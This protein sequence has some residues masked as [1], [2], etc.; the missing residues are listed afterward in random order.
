MGGPMN[1]SPG[2]EG[3]FYIALVID[4]LLLFSAW[5]GIKLLGLRRQVI[6][7]WSLL[8]GLVILALGVSNHIHAPPLDGVNPTNMMPVP[9]F[10]HYTVYSFVGIFLFGGAWLI[11]RPKQM[12][13]E[14]KVMRMK[15]ITRYGRPRKPASVNRELAILSGIFTMA[16]DYEEIAQ[17]PCRKV[18]TI[19]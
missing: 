4:A 13:E 3:W 1:M 10:L 17:N 18:D 12:I 15:T 19:Y 6:G 9:N 16:V 7:M 8:V 5:L 14:F 2:P 11:T